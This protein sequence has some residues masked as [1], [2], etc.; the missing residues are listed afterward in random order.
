MSLYTH[1]TAKV[2]EAS[3]RFIEKVAVTDARMLLQTL[4]NAATTVRA[5]RRSETPRA[6]T[7]RPGPRP[8]S[9]HRRGRKPLA[10]RPATSARPGG[11]HPITETARGGVRG[12]NT[13]R[14]SV[15]LA[16]HRQILH[17]RGV[18]RLTGRIG[19]EARSDMDPFHCNC[20]SLRRIGSR[21]LE[22]CKK[23]GRMR[24]WLGIWCITVATEGSTFS[25]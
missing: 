10:R 13:S 7:S 6:W 8:S 2:D 11:M 3:V 17:G 5:R 15:S 22:E 23:N 18:I 20:L 12:S 1:G 19:T 4:R 9:D 24:P 16:F 21:R 25:L 14:C